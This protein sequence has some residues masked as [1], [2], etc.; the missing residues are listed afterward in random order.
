VHVTVD[1]WA[2][3][4]ISVLGSHFYTARETAKEVMLK[5]LSKDFCGHGIVVLPRKPLEAK[6][7]TVEPQPQS[8]FIE[9][10]VLDIARRQK[11]TVGNFQ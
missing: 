1:E 11:L 7:W 10:T 5:C 6:L 3:E 2:C 4:P 9:D 8:C